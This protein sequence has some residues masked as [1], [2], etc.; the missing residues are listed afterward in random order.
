V[1]ASA[2]LRASGDVKLGWYS[3][4]DDGAQT[5]TTTTLTSTS[6]TCVAIRAR[7]PAYA[8]YV[9]CLPHARLT[10][11][12][13][14]RPAIVSQS[15][16]LPGSFPRAWAGPGT[17]HAEFGNFE[18]IWGDSS[19]RSSIRPEFDR[20]QV[21]SRQEDRA[22]EPGASSEHY[23]SRSQGGWSCR[24]AVVGCPLLRGLW[25]KAENNC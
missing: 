3:A 9:R 4:N 21:V 7:G 6:V 19:G 22:V 25:R 1:L 14:V 12:H 10:S 15:V 24:S 20:S 13:P 18:T 23:P 11:V 2:V 17:R 8:P 16:E 5:S